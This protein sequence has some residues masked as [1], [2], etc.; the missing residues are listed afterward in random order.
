ML[1][2]R[3]LYEK[4]ASAVAYVAV[5]TSDGNESIGTAFHVGEGVFVTARHVVEG[6][7]ILRIATTVHRYVPDPSGN[8]SIDGRGGTFRSIE[9]GA[10]RI[11]SGPH[12]HPDPTV[13]VAALRVEGLECPV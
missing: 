13:D 11:K 9:A 2:P 1:T 8:V 7:Q 6:N 12:F 4:Y 10:G 5:R 3:E